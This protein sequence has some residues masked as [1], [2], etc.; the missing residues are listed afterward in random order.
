MFVVLKSLQF[1]SFRCS[2]RFAFASSGLSKDVWFYLESASFIRCL[3]L[4]EQA[5]EGKKE[6]LE[7]VQTAEA[8]GHL[9]RLTKKKTEADSIERLVSCEWLPCN[10]K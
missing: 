1:F 2:F 10:R 5:E 3:V 6:I 7:V 4:G 9:R 8:G